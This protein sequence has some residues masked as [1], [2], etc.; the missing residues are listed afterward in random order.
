MN[1]P[2]LVTY[3]FMDISLVTELQELGIN[4]IFCDNFHDVIM[5]AHDSIGYF[6]SLFAEIKRP[7]SFLILLHK[8]HKENTPYVFWNRDSPWHCGIKKH[9]K[10]LLKALKPVDIYF[11]HSLQDAS[12]FT[13]R[14]PL[15]FPNGAQI[16]Y[17]SDT[18]SEEL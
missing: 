15:Y 8:L 5:R 7:F 12:W 1:K 3:R 13:S 14:K 16:K 2:L 6:G 11:A 4:I 9:R 18:L 17:I 10:F